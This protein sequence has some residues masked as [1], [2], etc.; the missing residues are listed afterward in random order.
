[1]D[2]LSRVT[3]AMI[4][5]SVLYPVPFMHEDQ[6]VLVHTLAIDCE[7]V[8]CIEDCYGEGQSGGLELHWKQ[9][10]CYNLIAAKSGQPLNVVV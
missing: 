4:A 9:Q 6:L 5:F 1:M 3:S 10:G 7:P 2:I 8:T